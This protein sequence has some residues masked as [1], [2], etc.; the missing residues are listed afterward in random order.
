[1]VRNLE[2]ILSDMICH[3]KILDMRIILIHDLI[4]VYEINQAAMQ[5]IDCRG[6]E[7]EMNLQRE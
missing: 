2:F 4:F 5:R 3:R 6:Q 7:T 1:M